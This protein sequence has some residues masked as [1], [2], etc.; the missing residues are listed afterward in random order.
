MTLGDRIKFHRLQ[1]EMSQEELGKRLGIGRAAVNKYEKG[2]VENVPIKTIERLANIFDI[3][4]QS[5]LGWDD[6]LPGLS[7]ET[8]VL[9]GVKHF[10]G[11]NILELIYLVAN[12]NG[13]GQAKVISYAEDLQKSF[14]KK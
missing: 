14:K 13:T 8:R 5:L 12:L 9:K 11:Q 1:N 4:P 7:Y 3:T 6:Q 2:V 10:Y